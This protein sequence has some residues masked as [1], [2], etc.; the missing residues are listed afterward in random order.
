MTDISSKNNVTVMWNTEV[1]EIKGDKQV[2]SVT[3]IDNTT[4]KTSE[5]RG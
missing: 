1:Q 5:V 3:L 2:K 4:G